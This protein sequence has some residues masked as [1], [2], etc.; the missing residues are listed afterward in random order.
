M[1]LLKPN[2]LRVGD[3]VAIVSPSWGGPGL[4]PPVF[5]LGLRTLRDDF[6]LR[7]VEYPTARADADWLER[8]P[9]ARAEDINRAFADPTVQ[10]V[11][12]SIGGDDSIRLLPYLDMPVILDHPKVLMGYSDT[13]TLLAYLN[14][15]GM[16][17]FNGP[18]VM[19]GFAQARHLPDTF[20]QHV[21]D[22]VM[23]PSPTYEYRPFPAWA[24]HYKR[25][26]TPGYDGET[27]PLAPNAEGWRWLQGSRRGEGRLFGGCLSVL[28]IMKGTR[29]WPEPD[30]A[31]WDGRILFLETSEDKPGVEQ[32]A[33]T[34]RNYGMQG[35]FERLA[36][37][38]IGRARDYTPEEKEQLY[39]RVV[40]VV[41]E[42]FESAE[43]P[44]IANLDF[45][46]TDPQFVLPLGILA[47]IDCDA[48]TFRL[49]E[50]AVL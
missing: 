42:E 9:Q 35:V 17:T 12:A 41:A 31:F 4:Y 45:G 5:D 15:R 25:W 47:E 40:Q 39:I 32:V 36:G 14:Q 1:N 30:S 26:N 13:T 46:H 43:L 38:L 50:P 27:A 8:N 33:R 37:L 7:I 23:D 49:L 19:A 22:I 44:I 24:N 11:I 10:A 28:D 34:L 21:R 3:A 48:R 2:R 20:V 29:F 6:G 18:S 16:V